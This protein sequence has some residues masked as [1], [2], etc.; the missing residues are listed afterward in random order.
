MMVGEDELDSFFLQDSS[1]IH[2]IELQDSNN[3]WKRNKT[4][5]EVKKGK[6]RCFIVKRKLSK[7]D[8]QYEKLISKIRSNESSDRTILKPDRSV[9]RTNSPT[10][11]TKKGTKNDKKSSPVRVEDDGSVVRRS[12]IGNERNYEDSVRAE[13]ESKRKIMQAYKTKSFTMRPNMSPIRRRPKAKPSRVSVVDGNPVK[14]F[15]SPG[16]RK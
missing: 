7:D 9:S 1:P 11:L 15:F 2:H 16:R 12:I 13:D 6:K 4:T 8:E 14:G 3:I 10:K 5:I